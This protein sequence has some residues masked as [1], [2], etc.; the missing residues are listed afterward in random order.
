MD[1]TNQALTQDLPLNV[2]GTCAAR[3]DL[4]GVPL[5]TIWHRDHGRPSIKEKG[6]GQQY[7]TPEEEKALVSFL[8]LM[9]DLGQ[10]VRVK[11]IPSLALVLAHQRSVVAKPPNHNWP[12]AFEKRHPEVK[13]RRYGAIDWKR[14]EIHIYPK[15]TH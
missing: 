15:I 8:L 3:S 1:Q 2:R 6:K 11:F 12:R 14:H 13:A 10:P 4:S 7:L 9:S 5:S